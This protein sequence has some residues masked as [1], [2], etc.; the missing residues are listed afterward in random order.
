MKNASVARMENRYIDEQELS[1]ITG[2]S[3]AKIQRD[4]YVG[5]GIP[6]I[7]AVGRRGAVRYSLTDVYAWMESH[8]RTS[9]S[10]SGQEV[11]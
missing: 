6:F 3:R 8:K 2:W 7:K 11:G 4:R 1:E 9:T 5:C 10:D